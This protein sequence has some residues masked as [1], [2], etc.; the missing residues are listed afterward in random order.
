V[1][2]LV[3]GS[4]LEIFTSEANPF[5]RSAKDKLEEAFRFCNSCNS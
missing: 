1:Y 5:E 2:E 3:V 4:Y